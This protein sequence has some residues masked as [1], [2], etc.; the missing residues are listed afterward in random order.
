MAEQHPEIDPYDFRK[1]LG[2]FPTGVTVVAAVNET[3]AAGV[4]IGSFFSISLDPPL[5]GFCIGK[6]SQSWAAIR[7]VGS[8]AVNVL[9]E[10]QADVSNVFAGKAEDKFADID[11]SPS[12]VTGSP[13]IAGC[14]AYIDCSHEQ[15]LDGGDHDIIVGRVV[16][17]AAP[18]T[19]AGPLVFSNSAYHRAVP[20]S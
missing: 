12:E 10:D 16:G 15:T 11:W 5:I 18:D 7:D 8:F 13:M 6:G 20:L 14:V 2:R 9:S 19:D 4:A 17:M 1:V 3:R